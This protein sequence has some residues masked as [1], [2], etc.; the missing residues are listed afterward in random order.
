M[1]DTSPTTAER[2]LEVLR[3]RGIESLFVNAGTDFAPMVEAYAGR[4]DAGEQFPTPVLG[5]HENLIAGMAHGAY[6]ATGETQA[7]MFHVSV[8]TANAVCAVINAARDNIPMLVT[9][10]RTPV[11]ESD[12]LGS[13]DLPIHWAQEM[14]DQ[15]SMLREAVKWEYELKDGRQIEAV[16]DRAI[17]IANTEPKGPVYLTLPREVLASTTSAPVSR[18]PASPPT[19][20]APDRGAIDNVVDRIAAARLPVIVTARS[21]A[22]HSTVAALASISEMYAIAVAEVGGR[23][24]NVPDGHPN[25]IGR[26]ESVYADADVVVYL[27][28]DV[29]WMES[30]GAPSPDAHVV[31]TGPDPIFARYPMR[32]HRSNSTITTGTAAFLG[33][34]ERGL[35]ERAGDIDP[36]RADRVAAIA[37]AHRD[38]IAGAADAERAAD[39][40]ITKAYLSVV[41]GEIAPTDAVLVNEYWM[42]PPHLRR[43]LPG[44]FFGLPTAGGLGWGLPVALGVQHA[45]PDATVICGVGDGAYMFANPAVCHHAAAK[46]DLP[47]LTI[48]AN[49]ARWAAVDGSTRMV[50]PDGD[51]AR[52]NS[53]I[54][55][56]LAPMPDL[57]MYAVASG[58]FGAQVTERAQL[59]PA[60]EAALRVVQTERRQA[61]V[62][63]TCA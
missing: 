42:Q 34:L 4:S 7:V 30:A 26:P 57:Q 50:Y 3:A 45:R 35:S 1:S 62:D 27:D 2:Y 63:V 36:G 20:A 31:Q 44:T 53:T 48:V 18:A 9:A 56:D 33:A 37:A 29:P 32:T 49:N 61:V 24:V 41:L 13:R 14:F 15:S 39:G 38:R 59:R 46:H 12:V 19:P 58:G 51:A 22:D 8:G 11:F 17:S 21:G 52:T 40:A 25:L 28:C 55:S 43:T 16:V 6:L 5:G 47:V 54:M 10:G 60:L 23:Y